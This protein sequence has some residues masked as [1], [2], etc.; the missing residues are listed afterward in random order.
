MYKVTLYPRASYPQ[1]GMTLLDTSSGVNPGLLTA[2]VEGRL[3]EAGS[4]T[5]GI[6]P[7]SPMYEYTDPLK[8]YV[9]VEEDN[10]EIFYGRILSVQK[11]PLTLTKQVTCEGALAF[12]LDAELG[13]DKDGH[14]YSA[15]GYFAKCINDYNAAISNDP[16]RKFSVGTVNVDGASETITYKSSSFTQVQSAIKSQLVDKLDGFLRVRRTTNGAHALDWV[17]QVGI[18]NPQPIQITHNVIGQ[19]TT[20]SGEDI[21]TLMHPV[22]K[23]NLDI[24]L[25]TIS[26]DMLNKYGPIVRSV[27]FDADNAT[28]LRA[29][30][31]SYVEKLR[32]RLSLSGSIS[33][34]DVHYLDGSVP[35][36][37]IGDV[38]TNIQ[39]YEGTKLNTE[40][41]TK[42]LLAPQN[43]KFTLKNDK[44]LLRSAVANGANSAATAAAAG[45]KGKFSSGS[46]F[47]Y[48]FIH[49]TDKDL[50]LAARNIEISAEE[51]IAINTQQI[52]MNAASIQQNTADIV[53]QG[54]TWTTF[55]GTSFYQNRNHITQVAGK[56]TVD[57]TTGNVIL[58]EGADLVVTKNGVHSLVGTKLDEQKQSIDDLSNWVNVYEG[59]AIY[60]GKDHIAQVAGKYTFEDYIDPKTGEHIEQLILEKGTKLYQ[61][62]DGGSFG[63]Y[64]DGNLTAGI[65]FGKLSDGR[66]YSAVLGDKVYVGNSKDQLNEWVRETDDGLVA[67]SARIKDLETSALTTGTLSAAFS[68]LDTVTIKDN[69]V[70][71]PGAHGIN[72]TNSQLAIS[73]SAGST[74]TVRHPGD[75]LM[76]V[77]IVSS[78]TNGYKL[79]YK[80]LFDSSWTDAGTFSRA[81]TLSGEWSG[82][83]ITV[84]ATPQNTTWSQGLTKGTASWA[85]NVLNLP[86]LYYTTDST[87]PLGTAAT[88][89]VTNIYNDGYNALGSPSVSF[90]AVGANTSAATVSGS[91]AIANKT[92]GATRRTNISLS[93]SKNTYLPGGTVVPQRCVNVL[94]GSSIV[95]RIDTQ[96]QYNDGRNSVTVSVSQSGGTMYANGSNGASDSGTIDGYHPNKAT[97]AKSGLTQVARYDGS[98][99]EKYEMFAKRNGEYFTCGTH[100]WYYADTY[101]TTTYYY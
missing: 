53:A 48:K 62:T 74:V 14:D 77:Q 31:N 80:K 37:K 64:Y 42:D 41:L 88:L 9:S 83:R 85:S 23:D 95:G 65:L 72:L 67:M 46:S 16:A 18:T 6:V 57:E 87:R 84:T 25:I 3:N 91:A 49:E 33:F 32:D 71:S 81:T 54:E 47:R 89:D 13:L 15:S 35:S 92:T 70:F 97:N 44:D 82:N 10:D 5:Y 28:A 24:G 94:N 22:G 27:T 59:T 29:K 17:K 56:Y 43:D 40:T 93:L 1:G 98:L 4:F 86:V 30:A 75:G 12:L 68:S 20:D 2:V 63:Y 76:E 7:S 58:E 90:T 78:G 52:E 21:F 50:A 61:S 11:N 26:Q 45:G 73:N 96:S 69:V 38:F 60:Q 8:Y 39:G 100:Y 101:G 51:K 19:T 79:Q 34:V 55:E 66:D 99:R 36:V